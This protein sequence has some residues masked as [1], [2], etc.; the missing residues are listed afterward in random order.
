MALS[1]WYFIHLR[2]PASAVNYL[3]V[4]LAV[5]S[6]GALEYAVVRW[7]SHRARHGRLTRYGV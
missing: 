3:V 1:S 5:I 2:Q 6:G 4:L 7:T